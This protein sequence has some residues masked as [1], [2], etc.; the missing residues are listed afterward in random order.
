M[1]VIGGD[2]RISGGI[3]SPPGRGVDPSSGSPGAICLA[4][5]GGLVVS[6]P[7]DASGDVTTNGF[8]GTAAAVSIY[9]RGPH[10]ARSINSMGG[11]STNFGA[12]SGGSVTLTS[13]ASLSAGAINTSGAGS[14]L[15]E[16]AAARS[17]CRASRSRSAPSPPTPATR[18]PTRPAAMAT[19]GGAVTIKAAGMPASAQSPR[20]AA[21]AARRAPAARAAP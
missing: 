18:A 11:A 6:G 20:A 5:R 4:A 10:F 12:G 9:G 1:T 3:D 17:A 7:V 19:C 15:G 8:G 2:V 14:A 21:A 13:A 16:R